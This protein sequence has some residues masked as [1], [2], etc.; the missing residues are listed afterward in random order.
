MFYHQVVSPTTGACFQQ[1]AEIDKVCESDRKE[2]KQHDDDEDDES[3]TL[4][5]RNVN[6][7]DTINVPATPRVTTS[8]NQQDLIDSPNRV[9]MD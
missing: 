8:N 9:I 5:F 7:T 6:D 1:A 3:I 4:E 2:E